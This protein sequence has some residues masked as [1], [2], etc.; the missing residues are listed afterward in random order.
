LKLVLRFRLWTMLVNLA[1]IALSGWLIVTI[2]KASAP[3]RNCA[4]HWVSPLSAAASC[5]RH[6]PLRDPGHLGSYG[7]PE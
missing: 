6:G 4:S 7:A 2:P 1:L 5:R 3:D